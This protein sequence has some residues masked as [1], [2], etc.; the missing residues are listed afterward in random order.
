MVAMEPG[1]QPLGCATSADRPLTWLI[2]GRRAQAVG[3]AGDILADAASRAGWQVRCSERHGSPR[4][5]VS[6]ICRLQPTFPALG[7][8]PLDALSLVPGAR[9]PIDLMAALDA[10]LGW[11]CLPMLG[12][13]A[14]AVICRGLEA[15]RGTPLLG[16]RDVCVAWHDDTPLSRLLAS[17]RSLG[18]LGRLSRRLPL[19]LACWYEALGEHVPSTRLATARHLFTAGRFLGGDR[20][21][22][23][24]P[25]LR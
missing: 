20:L 16:R 23:T 4:N 12:S 17:G 11:G 3:L 18:L 25:A 1:S 24:M 7:G 6:L 2:V 19:P 8:T 14:H 5:V 15:S 22:E 21:H 10:P 13:G 9:E